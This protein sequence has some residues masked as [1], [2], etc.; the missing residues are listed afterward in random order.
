MCGCI[1]TVQKQNLLAIGLAIFCVMR[2]DPQIHWLHVDDD[3]GWWL[4]LLTVV[5]RLWSAAAIRAH[6]E[7]TSVESV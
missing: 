5:R 2:I 4:C 7:T 3:D 6:A 1:T